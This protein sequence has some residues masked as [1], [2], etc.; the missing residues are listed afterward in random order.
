MYF[1]F[2][3]VYVP[4]WNIPFCAGDFEGQMWVSD[5]MDTKSDNFDQLSM[6][7]G[8]QAPGSGKCS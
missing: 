5:G 4:V 3:C 6:A 1:I 2:I 8:S 7:A